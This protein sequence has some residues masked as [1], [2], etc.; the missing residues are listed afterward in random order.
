MPLYP[1][2]GVPQNPSK[3]STY[4]RK[5]TFTSRPPITL[6][7]AAVG[8]NIL[9]DPSPQELCVADT[10]LAVSVCANPSPILTDRLNLLSIRTMDPPSRHTHPGTPDTHNP[11]TGGGVGEDGGLRGGE[12][13]VDGE[14]GVWRPPL[15]GMKR[16]LISK[17]IDMVT[18]EGGVGEEVLKG[19][20]GFDVD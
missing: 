5:S 15:G 18:R 14:Q 7:V 1:R 9:F 17:I 4:S 6:L 16:D 20:E 11:V 2:S 12:T 8:G 10:L 13:S 3:R 19:L